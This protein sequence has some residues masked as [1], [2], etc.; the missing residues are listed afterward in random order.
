MVTGLASG[1][2]RSCV[3]VVLFVSDSP[4]VLLLLLLLSSRKLVVLL[5]IFFIEDVR[6]D[7]IL[8][9]GTF[10]KPSALRETTFRKYDGDPLGRSEISFGSNPSIITDVSLDILRI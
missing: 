8:G 7:D 3:V 9:V 6:G 2:R 1:I 5:F 10:G 4:N